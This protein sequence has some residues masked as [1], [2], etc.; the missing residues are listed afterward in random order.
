MVAEN[1][2]AFRQIEFAGILKGTARP[3][4]SRKTMDFILSDTFQ[5]DILLQMFVFPASTT[6]ELPA[7][8]KQP[9]SESSQVWKVRIQEPCH[10]AGYP[11]IIVCPI[12]VILE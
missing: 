9:C 2:A 1:N 3:D 5:Q 8:G 12:P 6:A 4:L 7:V 11:L 10:S